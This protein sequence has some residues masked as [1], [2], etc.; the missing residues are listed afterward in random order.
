MTWNE[1]TACVAERWS[2]E[3]GDPQ[4]TGW[5]T[6]LAYVVAALLSARVWSR[7]AGQG[8]R[9][10]WALLAVMLA[11]LAVN[12]Q[13]DL[14]SALTAAGRCLAHAQG[15]YGERRLVQVGFIA[16]LGAVMVAGLIAMTFSLRGNLRRNGVALAGLVIVTGFVMMRAASFHH[17]DRLIGMRALG[18]PNNFLFE[19][20][21]LV[22]IAL[23]AGVLLMRPNA[24]VSRG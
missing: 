21:G 11:A 18:V 13:L 17:M 19:N 9:L 3:I 22:L 4:I 15:W 1:L 14:Q 6:V 2:L 8:G 20:T 23:N 10:F 24:P 7:M 16:T 5:L 12:K